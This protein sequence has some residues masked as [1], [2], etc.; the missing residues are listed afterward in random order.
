M[1]LNCLPNFINKEENKGEE[2]MKDLIKNNLH[3]HSS[4][5][6]TTLH[7]IWFNI[8]SSSKILSILKTF[9]LK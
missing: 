2:E 7:W 8:S 9:N 4:R 3:P 6:K 5:K 1:I